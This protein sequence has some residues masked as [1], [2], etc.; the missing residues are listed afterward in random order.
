MSTD[1]TATVREKYAEAARRVAAG[2]S[3]A[4]G[5]GPSATNACWT[6]V[7]SSTSRD[8]WPERRCPRTARDGT[9]YEC[10]PAGAQARCCGP[11]CCS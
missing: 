10:I 4:C 7:A 6:I 1:A 9:G 8:L 5:C 11:T 3:P 2:K